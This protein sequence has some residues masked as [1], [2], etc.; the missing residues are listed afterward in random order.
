V[1]S[2]KST[3]TCRR[4]ASRPSGCPAAGGGGAWMGAGG[5]GGLLATGAAP[6][7]APQ[8]GQNAKSGS[9]SPPQPAQGVGGRRPQ[10]GQN[11]KSAATSTPQP[12]H[13]IVPNSLNRLALSPILDRHCSQGLRSALDPLD[14]T[15]PDLEAMR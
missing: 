6:R 5:T 15:S 1:R 10:R 4:S 3:V 14:T 9:S 7:A 11:R 13:A 8:R 2:A 12:A